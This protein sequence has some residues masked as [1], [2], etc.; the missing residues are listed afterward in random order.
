MGAVQTR[1][2]VHTSPDPEYSA[3]NMSGKAREESFVLWGVVIILIGATILLS[4]HGVYRGYQVD[5]LEAELRELQLLVLKLQ[6]SEESIEIEVK[7]TRRQVD[8][9]SKPEVLDYAYNARLPESTANL[10]VYSRWHTK[11][12]LDSSGIANYH[13]VSAAWVGEGEHRG[14]PED[15]NSLVER[16]NDQEYSHQF[17]IGEAFHDDSLQTNSI[18]QNHHRRSRVASTGGHGVL[19]EVPGHLGAGAGEQVVPKA[20]VRQ[21]SPPPAPPAPTTT[22]PPAPSPR[23][24]YK[25]PQL[26]SLGTPDRPTTSS[27]AIQLEAGPGH[28]PLAGGVHSHWKLAR[29]ARRLGAD[30]SFPTS[31]GRVGVPSPGLY[32][33][34]AQVTYLDK[35]K[36]QGFSVLVNDNKALECQENRG[37]AME[38]M[39]H[40][41]GLLYLEQGD[42]VS[43]K[44]VKSGRKIDIG[45]G[46]TFFG[47]VKLTKDWI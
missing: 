11:P 39:C 18:Y 36:H 3:T 25:R 37:V 40:T 45:Q 47:L 31:Q 8:L 27:T 17:G 42:R 33:V 6:K 1:Q 29:W 32:L 23:P 7:R 35:H 38:M 14:N 12:S 44:D 2:G 5:N 46:K 22:R 9:A 30:S 13:K 26:K 4:T 10:S 20:S 16:Q 43:I 34:Y 24:T 28:D 19:I 21:T 15:W 41:G